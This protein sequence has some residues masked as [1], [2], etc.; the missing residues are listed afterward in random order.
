M[1]P[2][3]FTLC[4]ITLLLT[5]CS[6]GVRVTVLNN[7]GGELTNVQISGRGF[8]EDMVSIASGK[9]ETVRI[10]PAG[11]SGMAV[12]FDLRGKHFAWPEQGYFGNSSHYKVDVSVQADGSATIKSSL[13]P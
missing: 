8:S 2:R 9:V 7:S 12:A 4:V 5:G 13:V 6:A 11:D 3:S 1:S 10:R